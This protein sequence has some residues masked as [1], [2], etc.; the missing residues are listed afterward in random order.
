MT[1]QKWLY[2][3]HAEKHKSLRKWHGSTFNIS[4]PITASLT[5]SSLTE[6]PASP[7]NGSLTYVHS[8]KSP[9][10]PAPPIIPKQMDNQS[11]QT[12]RSKSSYK[13]TV[14]T[15]KMIG[16]STS[17]SHNLRSTRDLQ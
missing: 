15:V 14:T 1:F 10:I 2:L 4:C 5:K 16:P 12:K 9:R 7:P 11:E 8:L 17:H 3:S 6:I 13:S